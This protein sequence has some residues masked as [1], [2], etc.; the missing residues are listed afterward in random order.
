MVLTDMLFDIAD[1]FSLAL[2]KPIE[3]LPTRFLD[4]NQNSNLVLDLIFTQPS[5]IEFNWH[6][7]HPDWR[8]SSDHAL[9]TIDIPI[10]D[11]DTLTKWCSLIKGSGEENQFIED[12]I[13]FIKN[14]NTSSI[15]DVESLEEVVQLLATNIEDIWFKQ[16]I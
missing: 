9:I 3:N 1:S 6:H 14:S 5:S 15:Q 16:S 8:L 4:N 2:S 11:E 12:L 13:Q 10:R 7:I